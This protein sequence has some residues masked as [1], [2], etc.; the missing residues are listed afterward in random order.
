MTE[1]PVG[2]TLGERVETF[3]RRFNL[4]LPVLE[5][6]MAGACPPERAAAVSRAGGM[7]GFGALMSSPEKIVEW[8]T[9]FRSLG[10]GPLQINL[11]IPDPPPTRDREAEAR[12][13][14]FLERWG[15]PVMPDAGDAR[16]PDFAA[17]CEAVL[18]SRPTAVSSIMGLYPPAYVERLK[19][20]GIAWFATATTVAEARAAE[21]AGADA[22]VVQGME[23]GGH[24]GA[25]DAGEAGRALVGLFALL[26]RVVDSVNVP[27]VA[28]GGIGDGRTVAA[29]L[30]LGASAVMIGTALLRS[31]E[32]RIPPAWSAALAE[33]DP[34]RTMLTRAFSGRLGRAVATDYVRA[35]EPPDAPQ[36][37]PYPVQRGLTAAMR[38]DAIRRGDANGMQ[39]WAGQ[40]AALARP[41][42]AGAIVERVWREA[43]ALLPAASSSAR[44]GN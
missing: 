43:R 40:G 27:V 6:P 36:P 22:I 8:V 15:P 14:R 33:L 12:V 30:T 21:A 25:F 39:M 1:P 11:W 32:S 38:A 16:P 2:A 5:A 9:T 42:P 18:E 17:Q 31:P 24:R 19:A 41:E 20:A 7:G 3:C 10:G 35:A 34:E 37:A 26:P 29:A 28:A 23:A 13:A 4:R 44:T